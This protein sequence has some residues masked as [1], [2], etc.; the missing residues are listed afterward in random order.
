MTAVVALRNNI[1]VFDS[2]YLYFYNHSLV[3]PTPDSKFPFPLHST[4]LLAVNQNLL[5]CTPSQNIIAIYQFE[6]NPHDSTLNIPTLIAEWVIPE[7]YK[8]SVACWASNTQQHV[9][10]GTRDGAIFRLDLDNPGNLSF[11]NIDGCLQFQSATVSSIAAAPCADGYYAIGYASGLV[12]ICQD[13]PF[14]NNTF[15]TANNNNSNNL[16]TI[17]TIQ[18]HR[19]IQALSWHYSCKD[20]TSQSLALLRHGSDRLQVYTVNVESGSVAPKKIRDVPLPHGQS[21]PSHCSRF[22]QWSKSGKVSRVSDHG[23]V[24]SDVRTKKVISR[25]ISLPPPVISIDVSSPKGKAWTIDSAGILR[26]FNLID[27]LLQCSVRLDFYDDGTDKNTT[28]LDSPIVYIHKP[29]H[30]NAVVYKNK[31]ALKSPTTSSSTAAAVL[32]S[33]TQQ[34]KP[35]LSQAPPTPKQSPKL[36]AS[37][38]TVTVSSRPSTTPV[39]LSLKPVKAVVDSL[40]PSVMK[41]LSRLSE[42]Q[43][44]PEF[45]SSLS[46]KEQYTVSALFGGNFA[47]SL[48]LSGIRDIVRSL[49]FKYPDSPKCSIFSMFLGEVALPQFFQAISNLP[50]EKR[51]DSKFVF[52]LLSIKSVKPKDESSD[53][54]YCDMSVV[55][56]IEDLLRQDNESDFVAEDLHLICGYLVSQGLCSEA[57]KI[58]ELFDFY[59]EAFVVSLLGKIAFI[60]TLHSWT[61]HL[62]TESNLLNGTIDSKDNLSRYLNDI[63]QNLSVTPSFFSSSTIAC[64]STNDEAYYSIVSDRLVSTK[65]NPEV[66]NTDDAYIFS[67]DYD[68]DQNTTSTT[69]TTI[70]TTPRSTNSS[71]NVETPQSVSYQKL[72]RTPSSIEAPAMSVFRK[73]KIM[74]H[75]SKNYSIKS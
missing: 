54:E 12:R 75:S 33:P 39:K 10:L 14:S 50:G 55:T 56:I 15:N 31:R 20:K 17:H 38:Q 49:T 47:T 8:I 63:L 21:I 62:R 18:L 41:T 11:I 42:K 5:L 67:P 61:V 19:N 9:L 57:R 44:V 45:I 46:S 2:N 22:L 71:I 51:F 68:D 16:K 34:P 64:S 32:A 23:I 73:M 27:G 60:P 37:C 25:S 70:P 40:F 48:C 6:F 53:P 74:P 66:S 26:C 35:V 59:L 4:D 1:L 7:E 52:T 3:Q 29:L 36:L 65:I 13:D 58:Y 69:I 72:Q 28:I 30:V 24:V 43:V